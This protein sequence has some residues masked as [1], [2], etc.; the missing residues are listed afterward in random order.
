MQLT[1]F[2]AFESASSSEVTGIAWD[3]S[4]AYRLIIEISSI[5]E[6]VLPQSLKTLRSFVRIN[7]GGEP[8]SGPTNGAKCVNDN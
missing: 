8:K 1:S 6:E 3:D 5:R 2:L 7:D 4:E